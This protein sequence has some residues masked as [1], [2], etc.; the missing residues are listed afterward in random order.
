MQR[1]LFGFYWPVLYSNVFDATS[2]LNEPVRFLWGG[3]WN[4]LT[5]HAN[6]FLLSL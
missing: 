6:M 4:A 3:F 2:V 1:G 5:E